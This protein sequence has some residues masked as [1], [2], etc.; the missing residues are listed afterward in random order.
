M[1]ETIVQSK[2]VSAECGSTFAVFTYDLA[3][4]KVAKK[5]Q[6]KSLMNSKTFSLYSVHF[7]LKG[8]YFLAIGKLLE[9]SGD[10][11]LLIEPGVIAPRS[12]N[13]FLK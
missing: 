12:M 4:A 13:R 6:T 3:I 7:T 11:Y 9:G 2:R 8:A 1:K 5:I 10:L